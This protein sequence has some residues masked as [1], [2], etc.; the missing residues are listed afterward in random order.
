MRQEVLWRS[1]HD[2]NNGITL[3]RHV[4]ANSDCDVPQPN[5]N[6]HMQ[7]SWSLVYS[8]RRSTYRIDYRHSCA[9]LHLVRRRTASTLPCG[10]AYLTL[11]QP[12]SL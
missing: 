5:E 10:P 7:H 4:F 6:F 2:A 8:F 11:L 3:N 1:T 12:V 9:L